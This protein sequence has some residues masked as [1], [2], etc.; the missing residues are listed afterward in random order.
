M[1]VKAQ[2]DQIPEPIKIY[3]RILKL[4]PDSL[5]EHVIRES[6]KS[7]MVSEDTLALTDGFQRDTERSVLLNRAKES[8]LF[9]LKEQ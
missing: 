1:T 9:W 3:C 5:T 8:L 6:W 2:D 4:K 7:L